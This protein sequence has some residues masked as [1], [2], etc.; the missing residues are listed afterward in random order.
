MA[1]IDGVTNGFY[2]YNISGNQKYKYIV[3]TDPS[4]DS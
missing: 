4:N 3:E 1:T 2:D